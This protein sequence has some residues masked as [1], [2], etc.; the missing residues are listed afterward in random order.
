MKILTIVTSLRPDGNTARVVELIEAQLAAA[1]TG[2]GHDLTLDRLNLAD[3]DLCPCRGCRVC[4]DLGEGSCPL[5]DNVPAITARIRSADGILLASPIYVDDVNGA[6]KTLIDRH[7][8]ICH[9]PELANT[10]WALVTTVAASPAS[11]ALR[12][13]ATAV[14][15]WGGTI[16]AQANFETGALMPQDEIATRYATRAADVAH[17]LVSAIADQRYRRPSFFNLM[18]FRIQQ[19]AWA[20]ADRDSVDYAYWRDR[21]WLDPARTYYTEIDSPWLKVALARLTGAVLARFFA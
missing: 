5:E 4:F 16:A 3:V 6:A 15:T 1:A 10:C 21:G 7:A 13:M 8:F 19:I 14:R 18:T 17:K 9:R 11:H 2:S 12:T 20:E